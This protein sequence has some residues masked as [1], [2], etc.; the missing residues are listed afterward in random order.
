MILGVGFVA[1]LMRYT[2]ASM[3]EVIRALYVTTAESKGLLPAPA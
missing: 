2:R 1:V 3:L